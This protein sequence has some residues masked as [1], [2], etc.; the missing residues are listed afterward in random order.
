M[1]RLGRAFLLHCDNVMLI[2][3]STIKIRLMTLKLSTT[4]YHFLIRIR[5]LRVRAADIKLSKSPKR[6]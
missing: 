1:L 6:Y 4:G 3:K 5:A 2:L